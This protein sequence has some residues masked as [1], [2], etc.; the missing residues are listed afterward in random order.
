MKQISNPISNTQKQKDL[1]EAHFLVIEH[2][3]K[4]G[5]ERK[6]LSLWND[7]RSLCIPNQWNTLWQLA[8]KKGLTCCCIGNDKIIPDLKELRKYLAI[9][10]VIKEDLHI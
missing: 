1:I 4:N 5:Y 6:A 10:E 9:Q 8:L 7:T 3:V 2:L